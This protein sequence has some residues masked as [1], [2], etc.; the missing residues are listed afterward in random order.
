MFPTILQLGPITISS[1]G[2]LTA[3]GFFFGSF[4]V[5][6]R[7]RE[8]YFEEDFLMDGILLVVMVGLIAARTWHIILNWSAS[9]RIA[10]FISIFD[11]VKKPGFSW[12]GGLLAGIFTLIVYCKKKKW[13]FYKFADLSVFGVVLGLILGKIG[14]FLNSLSFQSVF[15]FEAILLI[16][17]YRLLLVFDKNYRTYEWYKNKRGEA[18][19]GFLFLSFLVL[20]TFIYLTSAIFQNPSLEILKSF[21]FIINI[22]IILTSLTLFYS[23]SGDHSLTIPPLWFT[24]RKRGKKENLCFKTGMEAKEIKQ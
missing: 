12:Q 15:L 6:Q 17:V 23:R 22:L 13:D 10:S 4:L 21:Q 9:W 7:G 8:E 20:S 18:N 14:L 1:L 5:W 16:I 19:F 24:K 11:L 2:V 3:L